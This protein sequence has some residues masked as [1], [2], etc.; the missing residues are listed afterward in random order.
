MLKQ[1]DIGLQSVEDYRSLVDEGLLEELYA[2]ASHLKGARIAHVNATANGGGVSEILR[3]LIPLYRDIGIDASWLVLEGAEPFFRMTKRL[4]NALQGANE[5][6]APADWD[7]YMAWNRHN[8][9]SLA[10][11]YDVV[12]VHDPQPAAILH[13]ASSAAERWVWRCHIDCWQSAQVGQI[14]TR[15]DY[16]YEELRGSSLRVLL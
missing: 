14:R 3:S 9:D 15:E 4:H 10:A 16:Y 7:L 6:F 13:F 11:G 12:F 8:A 5:Q 2:L 1:T